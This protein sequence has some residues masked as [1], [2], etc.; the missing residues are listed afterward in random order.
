M[1][2]KDKVVLVTGS[3][4]GIGYAIANTCAREGA[5]VVIQGR[6]VGVA[7]EAAARIAEE[8]GA[9]TAAAAGDL[10]EP[11]AAEAAVAATQ[12]A[13]GRIDGLVNNAGVSPRADIETMTAELF[14]STFALN[15][16]APMLLIQAA[17]KRFKAQGSGGSVVNIGSINAWCGAPNLLVYSAA[18]GALMTMTRNLGDALGEDNIRVNQ[19]NVGWTWTENE[20]Q[21]QLA[22]GKGEDWMEQLPSAYA[23]SG[24]ILHG[25]QVAQ[26][27]AFWLS[28]DSGPVTGQ[29]YEVEQYPVLGRNRISER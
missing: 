20:H 14:D 7:E 9:K 1:R 2:L 6:R 16:R 28:D 12:A 13:F 25:E 10:T 22:E 26:H 5:C 19:L 21:L 3:T 4:G 23:P 15:T 11:D 29:V 18:K 24:S 8:T 17:V 27:A